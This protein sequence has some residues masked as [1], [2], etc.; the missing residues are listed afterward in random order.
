MERSTLTF[1]IAGALLAALGQ[2]SFKW[3][4]TDRTALVEFVNPWILGGLL[5]YLGGT[6]AWILALSK[7]PLTVLYPFTA[8]TYVLVYLLAVTLLGEGLSVRGLGGTVL[9]LMGL[10]LVAT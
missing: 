10:F 2:V 8:L 5:L 4:A 7:T 3:G 1:A 9:V 6:V